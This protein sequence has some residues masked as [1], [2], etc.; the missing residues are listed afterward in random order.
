MQVRALLV[1]KLET[2]QRVL[3]RLLVVLTLASSVDRTIWK[4]ESA[5]LM[6]MYLGGLLTCSIK[7][8]VSVAVQFR[9]EH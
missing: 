8:V 6:K 9:Q 2:W 1:K 5:R 3:S 7:E 4:M